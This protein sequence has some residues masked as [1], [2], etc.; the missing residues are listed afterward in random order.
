ML[1]ADGVLWK[2]ISGEENVV[3]DKQV[4]DFQEA[5]IDLYHRGVLLCICSKN[6]STFIESSFLHPN[7]LLKKEHFVDI[8]ANRVDKA[9]NMRAISEKLKLFDFIPS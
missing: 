3:I 9:T 4:L 7:M 2:G 5:L 1:D 8:I 6:E